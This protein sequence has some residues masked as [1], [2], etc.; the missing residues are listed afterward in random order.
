MTATKICSIPEC[1][2]EL[3]E[4]AVNPVCENCRHSFY[5]WRKKRPAERLERSRKLRVWSNRLEELL[6][7]VVELRGRR[8]S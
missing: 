4:R 2:N 3:S 8:K 6:D 1:G 5:Y 7:N